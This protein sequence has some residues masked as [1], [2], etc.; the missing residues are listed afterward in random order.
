M[1][2][3]LDIGPNTE[4]VTIAGHDVP[5]VGVSARA[6]YGLL[7]NYPQLRRVI[8]QKALDS[9]MVQELLLRAPETLAEI[10]AAG[11]G[12]PNEEDY[13]R[14][15]SNRTLGEQYDLI[16]A[17]LRMTFPQGIKSFLE[18]LQKAVASVGG[19][20]WDQAT[21]SPVPSSDA[22]SM[23]TTSTDAGDTLH[24]S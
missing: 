4:N 20:G 11:I 23:D 2:S 14:W 24:A 15:A 7:L 5:V 12:H 10:I 1:V 19:P 6:I 13:I 21:K 9:D 8:A 16:A 17:T 18:G 22:S 3:I